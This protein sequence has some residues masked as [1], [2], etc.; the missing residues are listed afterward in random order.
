MNKKDECPGAKNI[1]RPTPAYRKCP[2]CGAYV[3][4]WSDEAKTKCVC[5]ETIFLEETPSCIQ[6][7]PTARECI[8]SEKYEK[9]VKTQKKR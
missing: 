4:V 7:C 6:W 8:G 9:L 1:R 5:R 2:T 3:E